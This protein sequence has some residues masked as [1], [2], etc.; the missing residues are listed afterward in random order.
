MVPI[1]R[2]IR[3]DYQSFTFADIT[4]CIGIDGNIYVRDK[5]S[6]I[7]VIYD[8]ESEKPHFEPL[9]ERIPD[10]HIVFPNYLFPYKTFGC[11]INCNKTAVF[12]YAGSKKEIQYFRWDFGD[13][14]EINNETS[15][16]HIYKEDGKYTVILTLKFS[17]GMSQI[18]EKE[19]TIKTLSEK[20]KIICE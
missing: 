13:G 9:Y 18:L 4:F 14:T 2:H 5:E 12:S 6:S 19:I 15:P 1:N 7:S 16:T 8:S 17:D 3:T 11:K 10:A 20:P